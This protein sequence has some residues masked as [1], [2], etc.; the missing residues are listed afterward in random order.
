MRAIQMI[1]VSHTV[2]LGD[3]RFARTSGKSRR[4]ISMVNALE[5]AH[6]LCVCFLHAHDGRSDLVQ[7]SLDD[8]VHAVV[9]TPPK[10]VVHQ[11]A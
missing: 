7:I 6:E 10:I 5:G 1:D 11:N 2:Q 3:M 4:R 8:I 9:T